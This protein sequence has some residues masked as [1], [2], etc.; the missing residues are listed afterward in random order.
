[1]K[2]LINFL[3]WVALVA[4]VVAI[5]WVMTR[6]DPP[7]DYDP[8]SWHN[9][10][11]FMTISYA[12]VTREESRVYPSSEVLASHLEALKAAGYHTVTPEDVDAFMG[13]RAP[14]PDKAL[15]ILFEGARKETF[16]RAHPILRRLGMQAT[17]CVPT[18]SVENWDESRLK[19]RDVRKLVRLP[20]W[21]IASLGHESVE[22]IVVSETE[23][24]DHFLSARQW[25]HKKK[26]FEADEEFKKRVEADYR[27]STE[28]L[29][30][31]NQ[32]PVV[33]YVYPFADNGRRVGA[34]PLAAIVNYSC[35]TS[36]YRLAFV[37]AA[38]P[39]NSL[40][41]N[42]YELSRLRVEGDWSPAQIVTR[43]KQAV[44]LTM[45]ISG[46]E[47][48]HRWMFLNGARVTHDGLKM[49]TG[50][51][52]WLKGTDLWI[53]A[54][55]S[56][57]IDRPDGG[58]AA[59]YARFQDPADCVR[60]TFSDKDIRLQESR[61]G[62]PVTIAVAPASTGRVIRLEWRLKGRRAWVKVNGTLAFGPV[63]LS[64]PPYSGTI[65]FESTAGHL[66]LSGLEV[67]PLPRRGILAGSWAAIDAVQRIGI[68]EYLADFPAP[69]R[70]LDV[71]HSLDFI[72][73]VSEGTRVWPV[74]RS[75]NVGKMNEA[76]LKAMMGVLDHKDLRPFVA[77]FVLDAQD[78]DLAGW[79]R[80]Q[81]FGVMH[82]VKSGETMP[83]EA[84]NRVDW[85]WLEG[86]G[87]NVMAV[88]TEFL[89]RHSPS[90]LM[91]GDEAVLARFTRVG[92]IV[93][94]K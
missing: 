41:R 23:A 40:G 3:Q 85:V 20:Q 64:E 30:R 5:I 46:V 42:P 29:N 2:R 69:G 27:I 77:G 22:P 83:L 59:C 57:V 67:N 44:P 50:D 74:L 37:S 72:Q 31:V 45:P 73:A 63:P 91:V 47:G 9:W 87:S 13:R 55:I 24:T 52:A 84:T 32:S 34:D 38:N 78:R 43:L 48:T 16:I 76:D 79:L 25:L 18:E 89:H 39:Y 56:A 93:R 35:V 66:T 21:S 7:L 14:L 12:G 51:A 60:L 65:G 82:R 1:M 53:D 61:E 11:G 19:E 28:I 92:Q 58:I 15:L 81:G 49:G 70:E 90:Q 6:P 26:R 86:E 62:S 80:E 4:V 75:D 94:Q 68:T 88:A 71:Q 36:R 10:D 54:D 8:A 33:A 17:L